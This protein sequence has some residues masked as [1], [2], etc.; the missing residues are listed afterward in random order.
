VTETDCL[1]G[2]MRQ[3]SQTFAESM[4]QRIVQIPKGQPAETLVVVPVA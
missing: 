1:T 3:S 4:K 2:Q